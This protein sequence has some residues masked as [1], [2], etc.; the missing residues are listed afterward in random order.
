MKKIIFHLK[1]LVHDGF[2]LI[3]DDAQVKKKNQMHGLP[4]LSLIHSSEIKPL[5]PFFFHFPPDQNHPPKY[6]SINSIA[7][8]K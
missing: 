8:T 3:S 2:F 1:F 4:L 6:K 5:P 7:C